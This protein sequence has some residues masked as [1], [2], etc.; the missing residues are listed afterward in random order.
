MRLRGLFGCAGLAVLCALP[1][2]ASGETLRAE[3]VLPP[4][5]S[6]FVSV[7]GLPTGTGSPHLTDQVEL[8]TGFDYKP[9]DFH[10]PGDRESPRPGVTI[11]RDS[12]GVPQVT[13]D[14]EYDGWWGVGY[15]VAQ[16][17]LF[18]L[19]LFKR[20]GSGRLAEILG[21]EYLDDD[22]IARRDYYT[23]A[24]VDRMLSRLPARL[25]QRGRA[26]RDGI[27]AWIEHVRTHPDDLPGEFAA[28]GELPADWTVR[29][30]A[31]V[32]ILLARTVPSGDGNELPNAQALE[33]IGAR[34]FDRLHP[35]R[36]D[37]QRPTIP[38]SEGTFP[39]QPGRDRSD[40]RVGFRR[41]RRY[42]DRIDLGSRSIEDTATDQ[43]AS[44]DGAA[45]GADLDAL[46]QAPGGSFMWAIRDETDGRAYLFNGPQLGFSIPELFVEF[47]LHS[48]MHPNLRGVSA[49]GVPVMGIGHNGKVAWGF[50]SGLSDED[51]LYVER[52]TGDETYRFRGEE[53]QMRCRDETFV[54]REAPTGLPGLVEEPGLPAGR[55]TERVCRTEHGPVQARG[56]GVALSR[57]YA[58]WNRE[59]ET[60]VGLDALNR[61]RTV[62]D[63]DRAM[64]RVTWNENVLAVDDHGQIGYW[65]PG[66]H[67]LRPLR[68]DER[69]PLPGVGSAEWR[70]L[71]PRARTPHV[72][73]PERNWLTNWNNVPSEG[74]TNG[75]GPAR[76]RLA[77]S[78]HR[79][80]LLERLVRRVARAPSYERSRDIVLTSG[81]TAQQFPFADQRKLDWALR[82]AEE[83]PARRALRAL[84]RWDGDYDAADA[85]GT[86]QPGVA[87]WEK[88]KDALE[89]IALNRLGGE[90][91]EILAGETSLSHQF[92]ISNGES[93]A[94]RTLRGPAYASAARRAGKR[95]ERE[96]E[97][98]RA[99]DW[100]EPR[101]MYEVAPMGAA[102]S[103]DLPFFDR[104][105]WEQ[106]L[107]LGRRR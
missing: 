61:A 44:G 55:H 3:S 2:P 13:G 35:V 76:E 65:H 88:F 90:G 71:L 104:G 4:G 75:D 8:F 27:N 48:P 97:S 33:S 19:E 107:A 66:L 31:R 25:Q 56:D 45:A 47:E 57:R 77:G 10:Q 72:V 42:L 86:V 100:R 7:A 51:D 28:L 5:Q 87:V 12:F 84:E 21:R 74:W 102:S 26:Y 32:G 91:T 29:D 105:T 6:G 22:I 58:I 52:V 95:L 64:R 49:A 94:L 60:L 30:S 63:V 40:E 20:A 37:G 39:A 16:D 23:D 17:R 69:L 41:S 43:E 96:F 67:P 98:T 15:A 54:I 18:Q 24:E 34:D 82:H 93:F 46:L 70:G 99:S 9:L 85:Q 50:T 14:T 78:L 73:D 79:V 38:A 89:R 1:A 36:T 68:W 11:V 62:A 83:R 59:L 103:P 53:R 101:R 81:T 80:R 92:D 106:A